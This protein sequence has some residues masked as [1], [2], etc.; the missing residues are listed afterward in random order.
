MVGAEKFSANLQPLFERVFC[1]IILLG[2]QKNS[3][4]LVLTIRIFGVF[5]A[6]ISLGHAVGGFGGLQ[7]LR[8][9]GFF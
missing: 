5:N 8:I 1:F 3:A 4:D 7:R 6:K 9:G 2:F